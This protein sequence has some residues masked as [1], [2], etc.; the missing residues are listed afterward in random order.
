MTYRGGRAQAAYIW[1]RRQAAELV[2]RSEK[3][4]EALVVDYAADGHPIGIE[5]LSPSALTVVSLNEV[6]CRLG[7]RPFSA[8][9]AA[10]LCA[11]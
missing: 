4:S 6:L 2:T 8:A 11:T 10:P 3:Q 7:Q 5:I 9:E 1:F